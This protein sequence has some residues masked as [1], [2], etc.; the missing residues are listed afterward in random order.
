MKDIMEVL[1]DIKKSIVCYYGK[2]CMILWKALY[3][4]VESALTELL[5]SELSSEHKLIGKV[6]T[7]PNNF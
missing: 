7:K 6:L 4:I 3:D 5:I 2:Y 1:Y